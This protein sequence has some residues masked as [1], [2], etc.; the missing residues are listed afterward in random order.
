MAAPVQ[1]ALLEVRDLSISYD[2]TGDPRPAV[3]NLNFSVSAGEVLGI[4]GRSGCG[5]TSTALALL[6]LLPGGVHVEGAVLYQDRNLL[7]LAERELC[8][9]RGREISI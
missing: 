9:I 3:R 7:T 6:N 5:K 8:K 1:R 4:Q 2:G